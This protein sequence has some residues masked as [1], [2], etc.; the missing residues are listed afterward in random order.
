MHDIDT[1]CDSPPAESTEDLFLAMIHKHS[2]RASKP[3]SHHGDVRSVMSQSV[4]PA[5][6]KPAI[7][8]AKAQVQDHKIL[9]NRH[10]Y[11][12]QGQV[13]DIQYTV[14]QASTN[15]NSGALID[16]GANRGI[17]GNDTRVIER[18]PHWTVDIRGIDNHELTAIPIIT[19]GAVAKTQRGKVVIIMHQYVY[20]PQQGR[21]I[22][23]SC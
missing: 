20:H 22:H 23:S 16:R 1:V 21:Y 10:M 5:S 17:A 4:K 14:S 15:K 13:Y 8:A 3:K 6:I 19:A 11:I 9:I 12:R 2:D 7:K 18:H